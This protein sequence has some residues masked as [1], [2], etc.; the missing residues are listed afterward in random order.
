MVEQGI[1]RFVCSIWK[2][3]SRFRKRGTIW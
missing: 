1:R 2:I 3:K